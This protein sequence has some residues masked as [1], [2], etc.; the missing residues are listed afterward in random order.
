MGS[1]GLNENGPHRLIYLN[2]WFPVGGLF[3]KD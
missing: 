3:G 2:V 1:D